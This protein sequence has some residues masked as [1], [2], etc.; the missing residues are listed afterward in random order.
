[1]RAQPWRGNVRELVNAVERATIIS[2]GQTLE[3]GDGQPLPAPTID[4]PVPPA[5]DTIL[6]L[7]ELERH[8]IEKTLRRTGGKISG[9][10]G[11]A[12][13]LGI[14]PNTLRSRMKKLGLGGSR[15]YRGSN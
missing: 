4:S 3:L 7:E 14:N 11:A 8:H 5:D 15:D 9:A 12:E 2:R 10:G 6:T 1:M 13:I